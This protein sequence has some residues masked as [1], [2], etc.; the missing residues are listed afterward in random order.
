MGIFRRFGRGRKSRRV[1]VIG[2][3]GTPFSYV[4]RL[5]D[6]GE[7]LNFGKLI[8]EGSFRRMNSVV[9]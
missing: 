8:A 2:L 3:D 5:L 6:Q 9:P 7:M 1:V 4:Q